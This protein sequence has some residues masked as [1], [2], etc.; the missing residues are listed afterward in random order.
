MA[1]RKPF[2]HRAAR[3]ESSAVRGPSIARP[4]Q[5]VIAE[6][7]GQLGGVLHDQIVHRAGCPG[8]FTIDEDHHIARWG[9]GGLG[10]GCMQV[11]GLARVI[12]PVGQGGGDCEI[13]AVDGDG[14]EAWVISIGRSEAVE[15]IGGVAMAC[16]K[17]RL[18]YGK[19]QCGGGATHPNRHQRRTGHGRFG[20]ER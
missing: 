19:Q 4:A 15:R 5:Q 6:R 20:P 12:C 17:E 7:I 16:R 14:G 13:A 2:C 9:G 10:Q 1:G 18:G 11:V 8:H 3:G